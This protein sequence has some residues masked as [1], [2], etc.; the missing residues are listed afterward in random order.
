MIAISLYTIGGYAQLPKNSIDMDG[1]TVFKLNSD[2]DNSLKVYAYTPGAYS[3]GICRIIIRS[4]NS[5]IPMAALAERFK[6]LHSIAGSA[7]EE[8]TPIV[9]GYALM[10]L[11]VKTD[12]GAEHIT[13]ETKDGR[14]I[15]DNVSELF[16]D[17]TVAVMTGT[18]YPPKNNIVTD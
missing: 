5:A 12:F 16:G 18:C 17:K 11:L 8:V 10:F 13:I 15:G 1:L 2:K 6:F 14:S 9:T 3:A 4:G 7:E